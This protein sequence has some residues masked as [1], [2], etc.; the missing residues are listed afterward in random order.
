M[1]VV[2][3]AWLDIKGKVTSNVCYFYSVNMYLEEKK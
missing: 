1:C 2:K 3:S